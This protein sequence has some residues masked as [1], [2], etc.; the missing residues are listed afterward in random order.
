MTD[1]ITWVRDLMD[2]RLDLERAPNPWTTPPL[3]SS[4]VSLVEDSTG[5]LA[6]IHRNPDDKD[7]IGKQIGRTLCM[8][9][10]VAGWLNLTPEAGAFPVDPV[11]MEMSG[12]GLAL[13]TANLCGGV[14][15]IVINGPYDLIELQVY[16]DQVLSRILCLANLHDL[17]PYACLNNWLAE[18]RKRCWNGN[19]VHA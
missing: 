18:V 9:G 16:L 17:D 4:A 6:A 14:A 19:G 2:E 11:R 7:P 10:T 1:Y 3:W 13:E 15:E 5:L 8:L 12:L